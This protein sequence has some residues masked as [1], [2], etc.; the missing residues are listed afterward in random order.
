[1]SG[2]L[3]ELSELE[4]RTEQNRKD[5]KAAEFPRMSRFLVNECNQTAEGVECH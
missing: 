3:K 2:E 5:N 1:M 4:S